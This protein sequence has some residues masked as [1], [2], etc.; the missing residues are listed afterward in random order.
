MT[1][2]YAAP[3]ACLDDKHADSFRVASLA[4]FVFGTYLTLPDLYRTVRNLYFNFGD[5]MIQTGVLES[6]LMSILIGVSIMVTTGLTAYVEWFPDTYVRRLLAPALTMLVIVTSIVVVR[7]L[8]IFLPVLTP[9]WAQQN[10]RV[11]LGVAFCICA[12]AYVGL[13]YR[14]HRSMRSALRNG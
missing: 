3:K 13:L 5:F 9:A 12:W 10:P 2:P 11:M 6:T 1:N 8:I 14:R 7:F 4:L